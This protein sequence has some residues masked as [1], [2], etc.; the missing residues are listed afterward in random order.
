MPRCQTP[1][2]SQEN[3]RNFLLK[4]DCILLVSPGAAGVATQLR[5]PVDMEPVVG[6][7]DPG[8]PVG[9]RLLRQL[10]D[11]LVPQLAHVHLEREQGEHHEAEHGQ[12]HHLRQLLDRVE[13]GIDDSLKACEWKAILTSGFNAYGVRFYLA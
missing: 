13:E 9:G 5:L 10:H 4:R 3:T 8:G 2:V 11:A 7:P 6:V 12:G 1:K